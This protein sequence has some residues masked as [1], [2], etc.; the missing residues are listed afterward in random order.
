MFKAAGLTDP[1][2][3]T[4][5]LTDDAKKLTEFNPDGS[6]K[7][8]GFV[9][10]TRLLLLQHDLVNLGPHVRAP[11]WYD[12]DGSPAFASDPAWAEMFAV[13]ARFHRRGL[14]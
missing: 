1:P 12:E 2:K 3:T 11:S 5:E 4:D 7:V 6:I 9:P 14:R 10:V 13:A 8:A